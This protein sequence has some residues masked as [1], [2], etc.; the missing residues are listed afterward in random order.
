[1]LR[2][3]FC[4]KTLEVEIAQCD[5]VGELRQRLDAA[6]DVPPSRQ[7]I[8]G[9]SLKPAELADP[10]RQLDFLPGGSVLKM[11]GTPVKRDNPILRAKLA[12]ATS[13]HAA[14]AA[15]GGGG[16]GDGGGGGGGAAA[17]AAAALYAEHCRVHA[18]PRIDDES[19]YHM[20]T[21]LDN[22]ALGTAACLNERMRR[23]ARDGGFEDVS[24][25]AAASRWGGG[26]LWRTRLGQMWRDRVLEAL[27]HWRH[28]GRG[29]QAPL[30]AA[31]GAATAAAASASED[32]HLRLCSSES[33][34]S[35]D[36]E[37]SGSGSGGGDGGGGGGGGGGS[38][39]DSDDDGAGGGGFGEGW[40]MGGGGGLAGGLA[41]PAAAVTAPPLPRPRRLP[42]LLLAH[43]DEW[44]RHNH[45]SARRAERAGAGY[46]AILRVLSALP[47]YASRRVRVA[48]MAVLRRCQLPL[49]SAGGRG[50]AVR[51]RCHKLH[52]GAAVPE[53]GQGGD[54]GGGGGGG[55]VAAAVVGNLGLPIHGGAGEAEEA[56]AAAGGEGE[57]AGE[58]E[59]AAMIDADDDDDFAPAGL[60]GAGGAAIAATAAAGAAAAA[61]GEEEQA[62]GD[63]FVQLRPA[64]QA[65]VAMPVWGI[66]PE[67]QQ[68]AAAAE[69]AVGGVPPP[70]LELA[71][72]PAESLDEMCDDPIALQ[73][74]VV[75]LALEIEDLAE[76][77]HQERLRVCRRTGAGHVA[78]VALEQRRRQQQ[79]RELRDAAVGDGRRSRAMAILPS[80]AQRYAHPLV[81]IAG[82]DAAAIA[83][84]PPPQ[85][86]PLAA[87]ENV[88]YHHG[89]MSPQLTRALEQLHR[90][91]RECGALR[92]RQHQ[93]LCAPVLRLCFEDRQPSVGGR[94]EVTLE[95]DDG[96]DGCTGGGCAEAAG[97]AD[98]SGSGIDE[99]GL[100][101]G[102]QV[103]QWTRDRR[104]RPGD[105]DSGVVAMLSA[106]Q[107][108]RQVFARRGYGSDVGMVPGLRRGHAVLDDEDLAQL[109][110]QDSPSPPGGARART[111]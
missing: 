25:T 99:H 32:H 83:A 11:L 91:R 53:P 88:H 41:H 82:G 10:A 57:F 23:L 45:L 27:G 44:A 48:E 8:F 56:F 18:F 72:L 65:A 63:E 108:Y 85:P 105:E 34:S 38:H 92:E 50:A 20:I 29:G 81:L 55:A 75:E 73:G 79:W 54:Q 86:T 35:G 52:G 47:S 2:V 33:E 104:N 77:V 102:R 74:E 46:A 67:N 37:D 106:M 76:A 94:I 42:T 12:A 69:Q 66:D 31:H 84:E 9:R 80:H 103:L 22:R 62:G 100:R 15:G 70:V 78:V 14:P 109:V 93:A 43:V 90:L 60:G 21:F 7:K 5:T 6:F 68:A 96:G 30:G 3:S 59:V 39:S 64:E 111:L 28:R 40:E 101:K 4:G 98:G 26:Q 17:A 107:L 49:R 1:M 110:S 61:A 36:G 95:V 51:L 87:G 16:G 97:G 24:K 89:R 19:A 71:P 58:G 13:P